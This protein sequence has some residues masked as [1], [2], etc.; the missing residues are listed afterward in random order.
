MQDTFKPGTCT[1]VAFMYDDMDS[2]SGYCLPVIYKPFDTADRAHW[3]DRGSC[4]D[5]LYAT[6]AEGK[7]VLDFGPGDG[8]PSLIMAPYVR[9]VVGVDASRRRV[10]ECTDNAARLGVSNATFI[11]VEPGKPLPFEDEVFDSVVAASSIE[12]TP[13]P[14]FTLQELCRVLKKDGRVRIDY[15][16][17]NQY[18]GGRE[19]EV[20]FDNRKGEGSSLIL[21]D[22]L[23]DQ[24]KVH[25]YKISFTMTCAA[26]KRHFSG[27]DRIPEFKEV[28]NEKLLTLSDSVRG[29]CHCSLTHPSGRTLVTW[30]GKIGFREILPSYSG[31]WFAG[32]LYDVVPSSDR[33]EDMQGVDEFIRPLIQ[34]VV[35]M[36]AP[37]S[38]DPVITAVK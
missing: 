9:E 37:V 26:L 34:I 17:L 15:E 8:W 10:E 4:F 5:F 20:Y 3:R 31:A 33:P 16:G 1:S 6:E 32:Q 14:F 11:H 21:Y 23:I 29:S 27:T 22:R 2:Q 28:T 19:E 25:M 13:D 30:L 12:Q 24:E 35:N 7:K 18:R 36:T 38:L